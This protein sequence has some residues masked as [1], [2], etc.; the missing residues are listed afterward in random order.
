MVSFLGR[1]KMPLSLRALSWEQHGGKHSVYKKWDK[2]M[3]TWLKDDTDAW[4]RE[5]D[6]LQTQDATTE[7]HKK[8]DE[9]RRSSKFP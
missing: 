2:L 8:T 5:T 4:Q 6:D 9:S 3:C 7:L 1:T